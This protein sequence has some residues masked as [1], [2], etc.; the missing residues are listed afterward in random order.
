MKAV[1]YIDFLLCIIM[2]RC[3]SLGRVMYQGGCILPFLS[4]ISGFKVHFNDVEPCVVLA[5]TGT[6]ASGLLEYPTTN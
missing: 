4:S 5:P 3:D 2:S 1:V 6:A